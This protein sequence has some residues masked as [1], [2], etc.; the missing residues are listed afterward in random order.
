VKKIISIL[1]MLSVLFSTVPVFNITAS[2]ASVTYYETSKDSVPLR[3]G[4]GEE[5]DVVSRISK[6]GTV[7]KVTESKKNKTSLITWTNWHKIIISPEC[8][9]NGVNS[10]FWLWNG[11]VTKHK[12]NMK[13]SVCQSLGCDYHEPVSNV[14]SIPRQLKVKTSTSAIRQYPYLGGKEIDRLAKGTPISTIGAVKNSKNH[15]WYILDGYKGYVYSDNVEVLSAAKSEAVSNSINNGGGNTGNGGSPDSSGSVGSLGNTNYF[16]PPSTSILCAHTNWSV[17]KCV[18]CGKEWVLNEIPTS[19]TFVASEESVVARD[20]PYKQ[21]I[22]KK[23]YKKGDIIP[24]ISKATNSAKNTWYKT[25]DGYWVYYVSNVNMQRATLNISGHT[26]FTL[27]E[28]VTPK[29]IVTPAEAI[30]STEWSSDNSEIA[31][32][33]KK[34][35]KITPQKAGEKTKIKCVVRSREGKT[36]TLEF[37]VNISKIADLEKWTFDNQVYNSKLALECVEYS[38]LAYPSNGYKLDGKKN[39]I[40][41]SNGKP[42]E[43]IAL[44]NLLKLRKFHYKVSN[45]YY[46][47]TELNSP[48][49]IASKQVNY[50]GKIQDVVYVIIE[51]SAGLAGWQGNM[52]MS[53]SSEK[54]LNTHYTF[55]KSAK[56]IQVEL[57]KYIDENKLK[58]PFV[59]VTGHSRGAAAGNILARNLTESSKYEKVYAYL[60]A[61]PNVTTTPNKNLK[62]IINICNELDFVAFIPFS[63]K[64]WNYQKN[65]VTYTFNSQNLLK[66]NGIFADMMII[67]YGN[68]DYNWNAGNPSKIREY[69]TGIWKD[70]EDYYKHDTKTYSFSACYCNDE[71]Y[72]YFYEGLARAAAGSG[73]ISTMLS[74]LTHVRGDTNTTCPFHKLT[75]FFGVNGTVGKLA[76]FA[77]CHIIAT[78]HAAIYSG[79][80]LSSNKA[81]LFSLEYISYGNNS[82]ELNQDEHDALYSFFSQSENELML[83]VAGWDVED[84]STWDGIKWN[85]D[86]NVVSIDLSYLNLSGW[87]NAN[88]Y[89]KLHDLNLDGNDISMLAI[90]EC[91]ELVNLSCMANS[92]S[93]LAVDGCG[94]LQTL[95]CAFN[96]ISEL[97]VSGM[98]QLSDLNCYGNNISSLD[99][100][101]ATSLQ[102]L[103]CGNNE[104]YTVDI[105]SNTSL[106]TFYCENNNIVELQNA[107]LL[108]RVNSINSCGG[109]AIIG[110]QK[111]NKNYPFNASELSSLTDFAN[112][113]LNL[114][115]LGWDMENPSTWQGVEWKII[116]N[117]YHITDINF[118]G[119]DLEGDFSLPEAEYVESVSMQNSSLST[120][121][122]SGCA[123]LSTINCYNSGISDLAIDDCTSLESVDCEENNLEVEKVESTLNQIGLN[124]SMATYVN[125]NINADETEFNAVEREELISLLSTGSNYEILE[126]DWNWPGT[127]DG[128]NWREV[129]GEYRVS[130]VDFSDRAICGEL[131]LSDFDY[132]SEFSF[133]GTQIESVILPKGIVKIPKYAFYNSAIK[134]IYISESVA[135]IE[136]SAFAHCDNLN[137][138]VLPTTV[139]KILD[140]AFYE[141][142]NLKNLVFLGNEPLVVGENIAHGT[143]SEFNIMF[144]AD[145]VWDGT[146][147]LMNDYLYT[148][149]ADDYVV[150]L[151]E[152]IELKDDTYYNETNNYAGDDINVTII[153]KTPGASAT[154]LLSVY[155]ELGGF[156]ELASVPIEMNRYMTLATFEDID[157]QYVGE[158]YCTLKTFLW[159][160]LNSLKP[161]TTATEKV[162]IKPISE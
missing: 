100:N 106:N 90:S 114:E 17:G 68:P 110:A 92:I 79:T 80:Q 16:T 70:V 93:S 98:S 161:L 140:E 71:A 142:N 147:E 43:P 63:S 112:M 137:T 37:N 38:A 154:C 76:A 53:D 121:N 26:F 128:I 85:E 129:D 160:N 7:F 122:L 61:T 27:N 67:E 75:C 94:S 30:Y 107:E 132:L 115:K 133:S 65:G 45:N 21:G 86:G 36:I 12:H 144:F 56:N 57:E 25:S 8:T 24:V 6:K 40:L 69:I 39:I 159:S 126:W 135:N 124:G 52:R 102:T 32:V 74:H 44:T 82:V 146:T 111:Y 15:I 31:T 51:G 28:T 55:E 35:G 46:N 89:P 60:F 143:S 145:A 66:S 48:F 131:D 152:N 149:I 14:D 95:D 83:E 105:S 81:N 108:N 162:L 13:D 29:V 103:R 22:V 72:Q 153:S 157:I 125:Q 50:N 9:N 91:T 54:A 62:N 139:T 158:E 10:V 73:G 64:G 117:E 155:D 101:G 138:I 120:I 96:T 19:D 20:V 41:T 49:T 3:Y 34:T 123:N 151:D 18:N 156:N 78:Y 23:T 118:D 141:S 11:N 136:K 4:I 130:S 104:L 77:D 150:L 2:A 88:N 33:D 42:K 119:L 109:S 148:S 116:G 5:V 84:S 47:M 58:I 127:W 59:V 97:D 1:I 134:Y 87:F 113:S 99:L